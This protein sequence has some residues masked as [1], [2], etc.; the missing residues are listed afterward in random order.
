L[1]EDGY[2]TIM[3]AVLFLALVAISA[4]IMSPAITGHATE[5]SMADR[6]LRE[7]S[8]DTLISLESEKV[9]F[10]EYRVLGDVADTIAKA[11]GINATNDILYT[12]VTK[13]VL[14]RGNRH[15]TA[16]DIAAGDAACQLL[17]GTGALRLNPV[18]TEY[19]RAATEL[20]D[21]SV[22]SKLDSRYEYE[23]TLRWAP[24]AGIPFGGEVKAGRPHPAGAVSSSTIVTMPYTTNITMTSLENVNACDLDAVYQ[25]LKEYNTDADS[26]RLRQ[27]VR[28]A[29]ERCLRNTTGRIV[30]EIWTNTLG[31]FIE[32]SRLSP[33]AILKRFSGNET[34][35]GQALI[36]INNTGMGLIADL[37]IANNADALDRL[38]V[39]IA[40]GLADGSMDIGGAR[41][42]VLAW[43]RSRYTPSAAVATMSVWVEPYA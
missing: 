22:R 30:D 42:T 4:V 21:R 5:Q 38:S 35:N 28:Q 29:C 9:D 14:G 11:C 19:D 43:L 36:F 13:A 33:V 15:R 17:A 32:D 25:S 20:I 8:A 39:V 16:M 41:S 40:D 26:V 18:T 3:D 10:F 12:D 23:F 2:S 7:L 31:A 34:L 27:N 6:S 1:S 24:L 37:A